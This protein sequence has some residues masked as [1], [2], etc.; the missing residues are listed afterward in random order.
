MFGGAGLY[1]EGAMFALIAF[2]EIFLRADGALAEDLAAE[3][4]RQFSYE[5][6]GKSMR[7][8]YWSLPDAALDDPEEAV[9]WA[10]KALALA[11]AAQAAKPPKR[12]RKKRPE[13]P[14]AAR[15]T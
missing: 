2:D 1:A 5:A 4:A 8:G 9:A 14:L 3:G 15:R 6:K 10:R 12:S 11:H 13:S 7:M